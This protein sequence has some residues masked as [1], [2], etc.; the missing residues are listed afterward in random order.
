MD[1]GIPEGLPDGPR[2]RVLAAGLTL[3]LLGALWFGVATPLIGWYQDRAD[4]LTQ[5][6]ALL[7][8]MRTVAETLPELELRSGGVRP[9][10]AALLP[11]ATDALA[12][13]AM[14]SAVQALAAASGADLASMETL[15]AETRGGYRR[16]GLR[17]SLSAPWPVLVDLLRSAGQQ[18]P[19]M[20]VDD[21]QFRAPSMQVRDAAAPVSA[22]FTLV[23][24]RAVPAGGGPVGGGPAGGG[25]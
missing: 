24:F 1:I 13:A 11:G 22:S 23:A 17:V 3:A 19:R 18:Q 15:P 14:Q 5:R 10:P 9:A 20:L 6:R 16:I 4:E 25:T 2:G 7:A 8:R 21:V 12:A